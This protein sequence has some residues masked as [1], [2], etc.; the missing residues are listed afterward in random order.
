M[1][2]PLSLLILLV[3]TCILA[4]HTTLS[5][6]ASAPYTAMADT[7]ET[8]KVDTLRELEV[9]GQKRLRVLDV[10]EETRKKQKKQPGQKSISDVIGGKAT[11][12]IM[13]PF[14]IKERRKEKRNKKAMKALEKLDA[15]TYEDE[16]TDAIN[17][18]LM[19]DSIAN[20]KKEAKQSEKQ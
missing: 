17:R 2:S 19:E 16:L 3:A 13:H 7:T 9:G 8:T 18:Q 20:A 12:Y 14:A 15:R 1:K 4:S 10:L 11:D 6:S 5:H